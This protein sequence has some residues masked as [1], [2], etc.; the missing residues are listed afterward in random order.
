V[1]LRIPGKIFKEKAFYCEVDSEEQ[2]KSEA[3]KKKSNEDFFHRNPRFGFA[4]HSSPIFTVFN[5]YESVI[6]LPDL[7]SFFSRRLKAHKGI[8]WISLFEIP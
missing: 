1:Y 6:V 7:F 4:R 3:D 8:G 5:L 2:G